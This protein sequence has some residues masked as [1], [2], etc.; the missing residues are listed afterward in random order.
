MLLIRIRA[1]SVQIACPENTER[2]SGRLIAGQEREATGKV[3]FSATNQSFS[4]SFVLFW[5]GIYFFDEA[6]G[7][8]ARPGLQLSE[9]GWIGPGQSGG[10]GAGRGAPR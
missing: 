1:S 2:S 4:T 8:L 6:S 10:A 7:R 9:V 5:Y 3:T